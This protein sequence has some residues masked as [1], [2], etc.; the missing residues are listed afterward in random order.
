MS[1]TGLVGRA[2]DTVSV[3]GFRLGWS[4]VAALPEAAAYGL[5]NVVA[6]IAVRRRG[7]GIQ[8]LRAKLP[9]RPP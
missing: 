4:T 3:L 6:D 9:S 2:T 1:R 5:F 7:K 8:R